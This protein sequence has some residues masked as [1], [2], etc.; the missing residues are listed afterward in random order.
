MLIFINNQYYILAAIFGLGAIFGGF[1]AAILGSKF[2]RRKSLLL[3]TIPDILGWVL[4]ASSQNLAMILTGR[5]L[6]GFASA[7]YSP[8]IWVILIIPFWNT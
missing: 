5:F 8:S 4:I 1:A 3:L 2:G 6:Q 7:G